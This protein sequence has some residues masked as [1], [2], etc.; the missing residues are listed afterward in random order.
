MFIYFILG[1]TILPSTYIGLT[2]IMAGLWLQ[3]M[4]TRK[5]EQSLSHE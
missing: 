4:K 3:Q 5:R 2:L 1:E